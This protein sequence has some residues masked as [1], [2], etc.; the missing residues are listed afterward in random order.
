MY[1][2]LLVEDKPGD[3]A[4]SLTQRLDRNLETAS[5]ST[6]GR[7]DLAVSIGLAI[8]DPDNPCSLD[9]LLQEADEQMYSMKRCRWSPP[10][11]N[12]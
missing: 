7:Y 5:L 8:Y 10:Y 2:V 1:R 9:D 6:E 4:G 11:G 3:I 12:D